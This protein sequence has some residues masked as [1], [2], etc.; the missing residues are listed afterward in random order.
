MDGVVINY[1]AVLVAAVVHMA[2]GFLWYG[3]VF[4][5]VWMGYMGFTQES[6]KGMKLNPTQAMSLGFITALIMAYVLAGFMDASAMD[7]LGWKGAFELTFWLWLG[8]MVPHAASAFIWEGKPYGLFILNA[9]N[10]FVSLFLMGLV[11]AFW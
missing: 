9:A 1:W 4:G 3:P 5:K 7:T 10:Q 6:M 11:F 8:F 2:V